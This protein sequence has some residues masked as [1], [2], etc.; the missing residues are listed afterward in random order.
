MINSLVLCASIRLIFPTRSPLVSQDTSHIPGPEEIARSLKCFYKALAGEKRTI[1]EE[2]TPDESFLVAA[3]RVEWLER[4]IQTLISGFFL[5][6]YQTS[7]PGPLSSSGAGRRYTL[8]TRFACNVF[9][10]TWV[11]QKVECRLFHFLIQLRRQDNI[12][13]LKD[14]L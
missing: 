14:H 12:L 6:W 5:F 3:K 2:L 8:G 11:Y 1:H 13:E 4:D 9:S 10:V 7:F